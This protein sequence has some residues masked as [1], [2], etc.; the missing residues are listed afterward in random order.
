MNKKTQNL[1]N[2]YNRSVDSIKSQELAI[3][4]V[5]NQME[6]LQAYKE[7]GVLKESEAGK[8]QELTNKLEL[9]NSK[10]YQTKQESNQT[11][12]AIADCLKSA[13][14]D[15]SLKKTLNVL[16]QAMIKV[17]TSSIT[18]SRKVA[19]LGTKLIQIFAKNTIGKGISFVTERLSLLKNNLKRLISGVAI[20]SLLNGGFEKFRNTVSSVLKIDNQF[21]SSLNQIKANLMTAFAPI[22]N[23]V[24]P[25]LNSLMNILA[26]V[27]GTIAT[28]VSSL[29]GMTL[30]DATKQ[31]KQLSNALNET[32]KAGEEASGS[33]ASF[34]KLEVVGNNSNNSSSNST[35][36]AID[37]NGAIEANSKL[38]EIL[39][40]IK[41][42]IS[43][44]D[45]AGIATMISTGFVTACDWIVKKIRSI[46]WKSIGLGISEFL[47]HID[48][49]GIL[50][51]LVS[52]FGEA[53]LGLQTLILSMDWITIFANL[54]NGIRDAIFKVAE[55]ITLI[56][57]SGIGLMLSNAFISV[58]W[59]GI[60]TAILTMLWNSLSGIID[61]FLAIEWS[62]VGQTISEAV[63]EWIDTIIRF[64]S[65][66]D[67]VQLGVKI[68]D[69][70][71]D[72]IENVDWLGLA[73]DMLTG[74][75]SG[76]VGAIGFV[77]GA[78]GELLNRILEF[79]G[80]HSPSIV[81]AEM[82]INIMKGLLNGI[83]SMIGAILGA[84]SGI[85]EGIKNIFSNVASFFKNVF[86][87]AWT[88]V[89]NVF[90]TS[91]KIFDGIKDGILN[92]FK[93]IV[94]TIIRGLNKVVK[95]PF[96]GINKALTTVRDVNILGVKP[97][98]GLIK[99][100]S[101]PKIPEL[102][103]GTVIPPRHR[104]MAILGD[105]KHGTNIEAPL[106]TIKQANREVLQEFIGTLLG[107]NNNDR[108]IVFK[109]LTIVAQFGNKDFSKLV[110]EAVRMAEKEL[111]K[112]L[113]VS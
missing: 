29:F 16:Q 93:Q 87:N 103:K 45:W 3:A 78:F 76:I 88:A 61:L 64:F 97:F 72:F 111:G 41:S 2:K 14:S 53:L 69:A 5:K 33:L 95:I 6:Q 108:E 109:N 26:Q 105:Q 17:G 46:D 25:A 58:D 110:V 89:K 11:K 42:M 10:L 1:I 57:W 40:K 37:Y 60:G 73:V 104:F 12:D 66:T 31:A 107:M 51:G 77:I 59:G 23:A 18:A 98:K 38:L 94:N 48:W 8:I 47:T 71:F 100:I 44:G 86:S 84:F 63:H 82:G 35:G 75:A 74:L 62:K 101:V 92:G 96:D 32:S 112:Q 34:D 67:W 28:F 27:T 70:I 65:E 83:K 21:N 50:V 52:V 49:S 43:S 7:W 13:N 68:I 81:F 22:Y 9:M 106:E 113:F 56:D 24:L 30:T 20:F 15:N 99:T 39:N 79:F 102:A 91:G 55:Y 85:W 80:I 36:T 54:G 19:T 4:K 90:S